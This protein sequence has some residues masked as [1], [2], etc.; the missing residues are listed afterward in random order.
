[1]DNKYLP[2]ILFSI[3]KILNMDYIL[4]LDQSL[5]GLKDKRVHK[6]KNNGNTYTGYNY[7]KS[8]LSKMACVI[9]YIKLTTKGV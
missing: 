9:Y 3:N 4:S 7:W 1:M 6:Q 8:S 5:I 2:A